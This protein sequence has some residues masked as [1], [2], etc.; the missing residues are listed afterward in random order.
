M[1]ESARKDLMV[2]LEAFFLAMAECHAAD[3]VSCYTGDGACVRTTAARGWTAKP[4]DVRTAYFQSAPKTA[5]ASQCSHTLAAVCHDT[6]G[7]GSF[8]QQD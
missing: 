8:R 4:V 7:V 2:K 1:L 3:A 5:A 6:H